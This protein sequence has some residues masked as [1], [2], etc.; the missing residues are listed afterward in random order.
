MNLLRTNFT[1]WNCKN[2]TFACLLILFC[3]TGVVA[4]TNGPASSPPSIPII[5]DARNPNRNIAPEPKPVQQSKVAQQPSAQPVVERTSASEDIFSKSTRFQIQV[6]PFNDPSMPSNALL[7]QTKVTLFQVGNSFSGSAQ[8][9]GNPVTLTLNQL[10][11]SGG[12]LTNSAPSVIQNAIVAAAKKA[13][14]SGVA[15]LVEAGVNAN[16]ENTIIVIATKTIGVRK[17]VSGALAKTLPAT[18][19]A[20]AA[21]TPAANQK[22]TQMVASG[23]SLFSKSTQFTFEMQP[24]NHPRMPTDAEL[25]KTKVTLYQ[26]G[27]SFS[28]NPESK[29]TKVTLTL[30][31]LAATGG[32]LTDSARVAIQTSIVSSVNAS[33]LSGIACLV[34]PAPSAA[35]ANSVKVVAA[36][37]GG[38]RTVASGVRAG[39]SGQA[40]NSDQHTTIKNE[41]P[42]KE[43][44]VM[45]KEVLEDYLYSLS[46]FPGRTVSA[47]VSSEP[48][49]AQ[50][51]LDYYVQEK[52]IFDVY[53]SVSNTGTTETSKYQERVGLLA[54]QLTNNDDILSIDYQNSNF[55]GTQNVNGYYDARIGTLKDFRWRVTGQWGQY[56]SSDLGLAAEDFNGSNWG[57]QGDIIWTFLQKGNS[58]FDVDLGVK[59]WNAKTN[60]ELFQTSGSADFITLNGMLN[61]L[62]IGETWAIQGSIG[63]M[64]TTT[65]ANQEN[66]DLLGRFETSQSYSTINGS[67]YGSFYLDPLLD[68]SWKS[69]TSVYKPLVHE[70][71]GSLRGQYAFDY[72][73]TPLS[74]FTMGGLYTVRG[75]AQS[76][77]AGD[78]ALVGTVEYRMHL[79]R[80]FSPTVPTGTFPSATKPFRWAP[81]SAT[82]GAPD[83]DLVL[84]T[85]FDAGTINNNNAFAFEADTP[86]YSTGVGLDLT[87]LQNVAIGLDWGWAL[88]SINNQSAGVQVDSGSS[89]FWFTATIVY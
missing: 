31:Q 69:S 32:T 26:T 19:G 41:S 85:F 15:C 34:E 38:V 54:T 29:G 68:P 22:A 18:T 67:L 16:D 1:L 49:S 66:L 64:Y 77:T 6:E 52:K 17:K 9:K 25:M 7:M 43:G 14:A 76:I 44:D 2:F 60:N 87:I 8:S 42:L 47:A 80:M 35:S 75:F 88:N 5:P 83:W 37:F 21:A 27:K 62:A 79:P 46:R 56:Y 45:D 70:I 73:L 13:G 40:I 4:Q 55:S 72:R 3:E 57:V 71:F 33:G 39:E 78:N 50:M 53:A 51:V 59:G 30:T 11:A 58:F 48:S 10:A 86:M 24:A 82:G 81:D 20:V 61:A 63:G 89:Q 12:S 65:N 84:S 36:Q 28:G 74:Q 23:E